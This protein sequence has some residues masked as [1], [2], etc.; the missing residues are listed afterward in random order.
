MI[1]FMG[2]R[3]SWLMLNRNV[4]FA[5]LLSSAWTFWF[6]SF[7]RWRMIVLYMLNMITNVTMMSTIWM[8][9]S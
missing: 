3:M 6:S 5:L 7:R 9:L 4:V 2:V 1:A 8:A